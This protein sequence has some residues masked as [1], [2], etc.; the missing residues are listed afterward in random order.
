MTPLTTFIQ[1]TLVMRIH[2]SSFVLMLIDLD[3]RKQRKINR[4]K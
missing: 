2:G 1:Y 4:R 3:C